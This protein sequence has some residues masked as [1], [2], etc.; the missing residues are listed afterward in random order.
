MRSERPGHLLETKALINE[1]MV[2]LFGSKG[3]TVRNRQHFFALA[4]VTM[5]RVLI[6]MG[7]RHEPEFAA[8]TEAMA[9]IDGGDGATSVDL[10]RILGRFQSL[11]PLASRAF[12]LRVALGMTAEEAAE[13]MQVATPTVNR[14]MKRARTWLYKELKPYLDPESES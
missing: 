2:R 9:S 13:D 14:Y 8:L 11:D 6:D 1:A 5:K 12:T 3:L 7:R 4:C 10:D